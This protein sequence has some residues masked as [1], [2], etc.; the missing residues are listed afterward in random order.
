MFVGVLGKQNVVSRT[1]HTGVP[2]QTPAG[3]MI[4]T[5]ILI[6]C[7][8]DLPAQAIVLNMKQWNVL[9]GAS[10]VKTTGLLLVMIISTVTGHHRP[11]PSLGVMVLFCIIQNLLLKQELL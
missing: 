5:A 1:V 11:T 10:T 9:M 4:A 3:E 8:F 2:V 6:N 7:S